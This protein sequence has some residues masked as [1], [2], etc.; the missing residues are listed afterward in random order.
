MQ[1]GSLISYLGGSISRVAGVAMVTGLFIAVVG[2]S[3]AQWVA[4]IYQQP[5]N[6][7]IWFDA[8]PWARLSAL[9]VGLTLILL[10]ARFNVWNPRQRAIDSVAE[11]ISWA[12]SNL[13]NRPRPTD[14]IQDAWIADWRRDFDAWCAR[15]NE[16][17]ENRA[18]F[19]R[20]D[21][22]HF[23]RLGFVQQIGLSGHHELDRL[24]IGRASCRERVYVL[25]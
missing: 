11:D 17:L 15:V 18:F 10:A 25:V 23:D 22:L 8:N 19:T 12:I 14:V 3:P 5:P 7:L 20:A 6:W 4:Q 24:Q 21:Q 1:I 2:V 16:K 13:V 9:I